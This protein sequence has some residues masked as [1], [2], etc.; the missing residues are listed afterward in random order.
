MRTLQS[1]SLLFS[2]YNPDNYGDGIANKI[3][4]PSLFSGDAYAEEQLVQ[5]PLTLRDATDLFEKSDFAVN[6][7]GK[8]V[9]DHY[10]H[11][12]RVEQNAFDRSVTDWERHRYFE[13]I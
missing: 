13:R 10:I 7:F 2:L 1:K 3:Q 9:V 5:L 11:F 12:F 6:A 8:D 4:P